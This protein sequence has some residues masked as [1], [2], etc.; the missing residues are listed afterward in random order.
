M[1]LIIFEVILAT[2]FYFSLATPTRA[3][4]YIDMAHTFGLETH[5]YLCSFFVILPW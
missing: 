4:K 1:R 5:K 3:V 2:V